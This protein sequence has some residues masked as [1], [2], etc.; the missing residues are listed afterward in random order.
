MVEILISGCTDSEYSYDAEI[1]GRWNGAMTAHAISVMRDG[2]TYAEF[3]EKLREH[4]P[5]DD[6]PQ[7]PQLEGTEANKTRQVFATNT[8][9]LPHPEPVVTGGFWAWVK[10]NWWI[11]LLVIILVVILWRVF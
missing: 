2:Q 6:Y 10:K 5:S 11:I 9:P 1:N 3:Y 8:E 4:L 7:T